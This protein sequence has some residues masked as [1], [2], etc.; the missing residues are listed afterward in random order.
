MQL[1]L[2]EAL[3]MT[4]KLWDYI[5]DHENSSKSS[6]IQ[7]LSLNYTELLFDCPCCEYA[8]NTKR[9]KSYCIANGMQDS[10]VCQNCPLVG[11]WYPPDSEIADLMC[12]HPCSP[13]ERWCSTNETKYARD[14]A[15][16]ARKRL[17]DFTY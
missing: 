5:A 14:V 1:E 12:Q 17:E 6:A 13:Y 11:L 3:E 9:K 8:A 7:G 16:L 10:D 2:K 15:N 4:I